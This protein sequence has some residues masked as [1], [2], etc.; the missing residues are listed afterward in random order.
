MPAPQGVRVGAG[1][2]RKVI[3]RNSVHVRH[4]D[5]LLAHALII[6][7]LALLEAL[8]ELLILRLLAGRRG[9]RSTRAFEEL[10]EVVEPALAILVGLLT[11]EVSATI[12]NKVARRHSTPNPEVRICPPSNRRRGESIQ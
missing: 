12:S 1:R 8:I 2:I 6:L 7:N 9:N 11:V 10:E 5:I 3:I 4:L